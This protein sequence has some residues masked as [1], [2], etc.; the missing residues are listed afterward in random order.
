[1]F[2][3]SYTPPAAQIRVNQGPEKQ[4]GMGWM[5]RPK[6]ECPS[7]NN[8]GQVPTEEIRKDLMGMACPTI[9]IKI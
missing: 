3:K 1:M 6:S 4:E 9:A 7:K 8:L 2:W 5:S